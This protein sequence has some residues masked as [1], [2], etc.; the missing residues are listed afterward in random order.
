MFVVYST[1]VKKDYAV[2]VLIKQTFT[3]K[4]SIDTHKV[5]KLIPLAEKIR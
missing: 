3:V 1:L 5:R 2:I 4:V